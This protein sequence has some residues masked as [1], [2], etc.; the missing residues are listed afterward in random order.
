[1]GLKGVLWILRKILGGIY[2]GLN[3]LH[4]SLSRQLEYNADNVAV[5]VTGSDALIHGLARAPFATDCLGDAAQALNAAADHGLFS[6]DLFHH[7]TL[8]AARLRRLRKDERAGLPPDLP[9]DPHEQV[10]VFQP[11]DDGIPDKYRSHPT[12]TMR[13]ENA[14]RIYIRSPQ[15][16]RSPWLLFGNLPALKTDV[17]WQFYANDLGRQEDY[18]PQP[19]AEVQKFIDAEHAETT[20]DAKYQGFYDDRFINPGDLQDMAV[21]PWP[22]EKVAAWL[23][24][25]PPADLQEQVEAYKQ[26]QGEYHLLQGLK[27]GQLTLKDKTFS[28]RKRRRTLKDVDKLLMLVD[29]EYEDD[30]QAFQRLD[31]EALLAHGSIARHL[32][33]GN[34]AKGTRQSELSERYLFHMA[35]QGLLQRVLDGQSKLQGILDLLAA[36]TQFSDE[37]FKQLR[38]ELGDIRKTLIAC[39]KEAKSHE[40]PELSN[41]PPGSLLYQLIVDRGD[42]DLPALTGDSISGEWLTKLLKRLEGVLSRI[43]RVHFKSLGSLLAFQERLAGEW[44]ST[45]VGQ[46]GQA[47]FSPES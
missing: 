13:E 27:S 34:R 4:L 35:L 41:V 15:D 31:R 28:F 20:F 18:D 24:S 42:K 23:A 14:K 19:A 45:P 30:Q 26:R 44:K 25:W 39:L 38:Y 11:V 8:A 21:S 10:Q 16:D 43:K 6:D 7:Q 1:V 3:L 32:D 5:S 22:R 40:T 47:V 9:A 36:N 33:G 37:D 2:Q 46:E 12:D 29:K 17:T